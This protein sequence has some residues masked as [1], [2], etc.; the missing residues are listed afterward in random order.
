M[1]RPTFCVGLSIGGVKCTASFGNNDGMITR[2]RIGQLLKAW[3]EI[4]P[5]AHCELDFR[6]PLQLLIATILSAQSTDKRV[7]MVTPAL[8]RKYRTAQDYA[9]A[10]LPEL[11][12]AIKST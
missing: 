4:Y 10:R 12:N 2:E 6:N 8:F 3:P 11:E 5:N 9:D 7:N 1:R